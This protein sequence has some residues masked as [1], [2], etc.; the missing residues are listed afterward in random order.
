M[1]QDVEKISRDNWIIMA[2]LV[3]GTFLG[4][5]GE[6]V[7]NVA[8]PNI[9]QD[10]DVNTST[11][12]WLTTGYMLVVGVSIPVS[13][14]LMQR[15]TVRQLYFA[16]MIFYTMGSFIAFTAPEYSFLFTGRMIQALG[17]G[18]T[19]P[20]AMN[21]IIT[22]TPLSKRGTM[23]GIYTL[24]IL[25]AP[26]IGPV[27]S[28]IVIQLFSWRIIFLIIM[29][30]A[31]AVFAAAGL[32]L[33]N[34]TEQKDTSIDIPSII[35]STV[36]FG[37]IVYGFSLA[38]EGAGWGDAG[39]WLTLAAGF[40]SL[41]VFVVRQ[42]KLSSPMLDMRPFSSS[43]FSRSMVLMLLLMM[44]QFSMM[45][46]LPIYFQTATGMSPLETGLLMLPGGVVLACTSL[47]AG[48]LFDKIGF[49]PLL[50]T[51]VTIVMIVISFFTMISS[52]TTTLTGMILYAVFTLG[53]GLTLPPIQTLALNQ[54]SQPLYPH[55]SAISNTVNQISG[56]I[57][58]ALYTSIMT[59]AAQRFIQQSNLTGENTIEIEALTQGVQ[60]VYYTALGAAVVAFIIALTLKKKDQYGYRNTGE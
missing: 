49:K 40:L 41:A 8:I 55:G 27:F 54:V 26:A 46:I 44:T 12:Q 24:V 45:M 51:G 2:I 33:R 3:I 38:G 9:M 16:S 15:F 10:F 6:T 37:G 29:I 4:L 60:M 52:E 48:R 28:G 56:A 1:V 35:L 32:K 34:V 19:M 23:L 30:L 21:V 50:L 59:I 42:M 47:V 25:F 11:A 43:V 14:Y 18:I 36:G 13:A 53:L 17:A 20:L 22:L 57:G 7:M 39:M 5:L 31:I 58:P